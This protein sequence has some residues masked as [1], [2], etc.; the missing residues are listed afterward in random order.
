[1]KK[2]FGLSACLLI[3]SLCVR[4]ELM[5]LATPE[6]QGVPSAAISAFINACERKYAG[7]PEGALHGFVIVRHGKTIAEGSWKPF[8][9]LENTHMLYSHS[10]SFTST[11]I[12]FLVDEKN[13][14]LDDRVV[15]IF[16]DLAPAKPSE[17]LR[18]LRVRDLLTMTVGMHRTDAESNDIAGDWVKA[19]LNNTIEDAPGTHFRYDSC[20]TH[21]LAAIVERKTGERLMDYLKRRLFDKI[22]IRKQWST[23]SPTGIACGGWGMNM[24]TREQARFG[25]LYLQQGLWNGEQ[26]LSTNWV[27]MATSYQTDTERKN[28]GDWGQGYGFQFWRCHHNAYR[29]DGA[30]GQYTIVMPDQD[31]VVS[32]NSG[33]GN[34]QGVLSLVWEHLLPAFKETSLA[35]DE[36]ACATLRAKC[37]ALVLAPPT[38]TAA[39]GNDAFFGRVFEFKDN[40]HGVKS[41]RFDRAT[42]G[43]WICTLVLPA[44]P[45]KVPVGRGSWAKGRMRMDG[46]M[47]YEA[48]SGYVSEYDVAAAA[49]VKG[50][51]DF[52]ARIYLTSTPA[53][54]ALTI[55]C[56]KN[57]APVI[58]GNF[59]AMGGHKL[60]MK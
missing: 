54:F 23:C 53:D 38:T 52:V 47:P 10:K 13:L 29:A 33:L 5:E 15:E 32:I 60:E 34:M 44:G 56:D 2:S 39:A 51:G 3:G 12:G 35:P 22:G 24:T 31:A 46:A 49:G 48:L 30:M 20:A 37:A 17:H 28:G 16:P 59:T 9:T 41:V 26:I 1:M 27:R 58:S 43:G 18:Q 6:S 50:N 21:V 19:F 4:A 57:G 42:S 55:R 8:N 14:D 7:G 25:Q 40:K 11:A 45:Q 36:K